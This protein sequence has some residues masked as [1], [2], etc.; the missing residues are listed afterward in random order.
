MLRVWALAEVGLAVVAG[1]ECGELRALRGA[2]AVPPGGA[3][4]APAPGDAANV[5]L[6]ESDVVFLVYDLAGGALVGELDAGA[7]WAA[8]ALGGDGGV[9]TPMDDGGGGGGSGRVVA[10]AVGDAF[11][12]LQVRRVRAC[13]RRASLRAASRLRVVAS[14]ARASA[15]TQRRASCGSCIRPSRA[16]RGVRA[17]GTRRC[18]AHAA[19]TRALGRRRT[20]LDVF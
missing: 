20:P 15:C 13:R 18:V 7:G 19:V 9:H 5:A 4:A 14:R 16:A 11:A 3:A 6:C 2:G 12:F 17:G 1:I 8:A 10:A